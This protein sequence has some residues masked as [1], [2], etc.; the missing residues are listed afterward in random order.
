LHAVLQF[1]AMASSVAWLLVAL[2]QVLLSQSDAHQPLSV[3]PEEIADLMWHSAIDYGWHAVNVYA[4]DTGNAKEDMLRGDR[5]IAD[6]RRR[7]DD[8]LS[9]RTVDLMREVAQLEGWY[10]AQRKE[11]ETQ[12][13]TGDKCNAAIA[14][15]K[16]TN[17]LSSDLCEKIRNLASWAA[18]YTVESKEKGFDSQPAKLNKARGES[19]LDGMRGKVLL[20]ALHIRT[21]TAKILKSTPIS[22]A[23]HTLM[24]RGSVA[25][26]QKYVY[27]RTIGQTRT[28]NNQLGFEIG[29]ET[30]IEVSAKFFDT[31]VTLRFSASYQRSWGGSSH[32][33]E[34]KRYEFPLTAPPHS[35]YRMR[36]SVQE[37]TVDAEY[38]MVLSIGGH[39]YTHMGRWEG[40]ADSVMTAT[41]EPLS[42]GPNSSPPEA[43]ELLFP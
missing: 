42:V 14:N 30:S 38:T 24:N 29:I 13:K 37:A 26:T 28:W 34:M 11:K 1:V 4:G 22:L 31:G 20:K 33:T 8:L 40:L 6:M 41:V 15:L 3:L 9:D 7:A 19:I 36:A 23:E 16:K 21:D 18:W 32:N 35:T 5:N 2:C 12:K 43:A 27:Q 17:E 10:A 39:E 25:Q